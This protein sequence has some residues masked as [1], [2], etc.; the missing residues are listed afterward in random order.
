M[1]EGAHTAF[2]RAVDDQGVTNRSAPVT[3]GVVT[4]PRLLDATRLPDGRF[5]MT[6]PTRVGLRYQVQFSEDILNW[7][8]AGPPLLGNGQPQNWI[9]NGPPFTPT[10]PQTTPHRF[11]KVVVL[12]A[13]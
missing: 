5:Q 2:A 8:N 11:Y 3:F 4:P 7:F 10:P 6:F 13:P 1:P 12:P 9:D